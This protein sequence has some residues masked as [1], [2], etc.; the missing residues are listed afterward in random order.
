MIESIVICAY[1]FTAAFVVLTVFII[2]TAI[3]VRLTALSLMHIFNKINQ[4]MDRAQHAAGIASNIAGVLGGLLF[5]SFRSL[6]N[7]FIC[8]VKEFQE[9]KDQ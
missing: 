8:D 3:Q 6:K 5:G 2:R 9:G 7:H 1:I 4:E